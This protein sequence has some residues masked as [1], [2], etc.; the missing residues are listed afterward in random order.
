MYFALTSLK[1]FNFPCVISSYIPN[2]A[3]VTAMSEC[4]HKFLFVTFNF[5]KFLIVAMGVTNML[6]S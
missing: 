1:K 5:S 2:K 6:T 4:I 3:D